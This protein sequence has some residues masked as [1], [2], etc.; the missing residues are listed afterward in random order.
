M[1]LKAFAP[2][3]LDPR[4][5]GSWV[6]SNLLQ[7]HAYGNENPIAIGH[8][9]GTGWFIL[10][11]D[12]EERMLFCE[13]EIEPTINNPAEINWG[14]CGFPSLEGSC[15]N[16]MA[17]ITILKFTPAAMKQVLG[18]SVGKIRNIKI[19]NRVFSLSR[20]HSDI[21]RIINILKTPKI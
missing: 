3:T 19:H 8:A 14:V 10:T 9:P 12:P 18:M 16:A 20:I 6:P 1:N 13:H 7:K 15:L 5:W 2:Y 4:T 11:K 21:Y 17:L